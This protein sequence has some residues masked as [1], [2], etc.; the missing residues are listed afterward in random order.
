MKALVLNIEKTQGFMRDDGSIIHSP[1]TAR[2]DVACSLTMLFTQ[3][4]SDQIISIIISN[5]KVV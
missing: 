3:R 1:Q 4:F 5:S 2:P